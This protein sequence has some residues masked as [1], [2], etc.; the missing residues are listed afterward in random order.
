M[1][2]GRRLNALPGLS[3]PHIYQHQIGFETFRQASGVAGVGRDAGRGIAQQFQQGLQFDHQVRIT[4]SNKNT[5]SAH[6]I[7][8]RN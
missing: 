8:S 4:D 1:D 6:K 5:G 2:C 7:R 3:Q